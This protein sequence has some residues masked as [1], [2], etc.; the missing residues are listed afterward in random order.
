MTDTRIEP[1]DGSTVARADTPL[2]GTP[3][4]GRK[5]RNRFVQTVVRVFMNRGAG[6]GLVTILV[7][8]AFAF[9]GPLVSPWGYSQI[10]Y[11]AFTQPP[12]GTHWFGTNGIGQDVF[13]QTARAMQKSLLI[14]CSSRCSPPRSPPWPGPP[15]GTSAAGPTAS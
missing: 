7:L 10:D 6:V 1:V 9:I 3:A 15:P 2:P 11:T 12:S 5:Q 8:F 4:P 14:G 13:T